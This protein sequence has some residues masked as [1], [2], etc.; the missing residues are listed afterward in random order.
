MAADWA[1][2][3]RL[4]GPVMTFGVVPPT[5]NPA[6]AGVPPMP[7]EAQAQ[8]FA[9]KLAP[10]MNMAR[11]GGIPAGMAMGPRPNPLIAKNPWTGQAGAAGQAL[12]GGSAPAIPSLSGYFGVTAPMLSRWTSPQNGAALG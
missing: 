1:E 6:S 4:L 12:P 11:Q 2:R 3:L 8:A 9:S 7:V 5:F 10:T